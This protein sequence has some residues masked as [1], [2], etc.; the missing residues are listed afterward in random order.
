L[1]HGELTLHS[2]SAIYQYRFPLPE[3][4]QTYVCTLST[5]EVISKAHTHTQKSYKIFKICS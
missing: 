3:S 5:S 4:Y 2:I 1:Q